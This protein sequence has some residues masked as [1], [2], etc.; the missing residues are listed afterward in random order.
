MVVS[1][2][3]RILVAKRLNADGSFNRYWYVHWQ[4][5]GLLVGRMETWKLVHGY[6]VGD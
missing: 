3:G 2:L 1:P 5:S 4:L 6:M